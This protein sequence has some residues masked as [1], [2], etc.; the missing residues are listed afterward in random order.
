[1]GVQRD[2]FEAA[3]YFCRLSFKECDASEKLLEGADPERIP[4]FGDA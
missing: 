4:T 3:A 2:S 1:V